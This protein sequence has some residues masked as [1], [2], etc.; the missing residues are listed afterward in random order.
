M[1]G[2]A[3]LTE[4]S[5]FS[6]GTLGNRPTGLAQ[7]PTMVSM[8]GLNYIVI[9]MVVTD[10]GELAGAK[11]LTTIFVDHSK[12]KDSVLSCTHSSCSFSN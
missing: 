2:V 3:N 8:L 5:S 11:Q 4:V 10:G 9:S 6:M 12:K 1:F 7:L